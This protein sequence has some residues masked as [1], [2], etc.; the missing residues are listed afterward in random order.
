MYT[1]KLLIFRKPTGRN[2]FM[3]FIVLFSI[4]VPPLA[5][6]IRFGIGTDFFVN[7]L[8]T[9]AG[10]IPGHLHNF[11]VQRMRDNSNRPN[12]TPKWL[13][14]YGLVSD[15]YKDTGSRSRTWADRYI[16]L[17]RPVQYDEEGRPYFLDEEE[18]A[19]TISEHSDALVDTESFYNDDGVHRR[20]MARTTATPV[21]S[22]PP[23]RPSRSQWSLKQRARRFFGGGHSGVDRHT[24]ISSALSTEMDSA[25]RPLYDMDYLDGEDEHSARLR[26][27]RTGRG[28]Q[29][30]PLTAPTGELDDLDRELM[31]LSTAPPRAPSY[32]A[33]QRP[34]SRPPPAPEQQP[35]ASSP[36]L[37]R[38]IMEVEHTF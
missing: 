8:L 19:D 23:I 17:Q 16:N 2:V 6:F 38:D 4:L 20:R 11:F 26:R 28:V 9:V 5:V 15:P 34:R 35:P 22:E 18:D 37:E 7:V 25:D 36:V 32:A 30:P 27:T 10:Y 3:L 14:R 31:G 24:R 13:R 29:A 21:A 33:S 12:R 1:F